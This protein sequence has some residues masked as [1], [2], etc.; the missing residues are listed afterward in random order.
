MQKLNYGYDNINVVDGEFKKATLY[1][2]TLVNLLMYFMS[3]VDYL[4]AQYRIVFRN[5]DSFDKITIVNKNSKTIKFSYYITNWV[6]YEIPAFNNVL[7]ELPKEVN[8]YN[9]YASD[10]YGWNSTNYREALDNL[11]LLHGDYVNQDIPYFEGMQSVKNSQTLVNLQQKGTWN[12]NGS[13]SSQNASYSSPL[14]T[15]L[16]KPSTK[17]YVKFNKDITTICKQF[18]FV[19]STDI[20]IPLTSHSN[21]A[22]GI[23]TTPSTLD[24]KTTPIHIYPKDK[25]SLTTKQLTDLHVMIIEYVE[26]MENW[27]IP[28]FEGTLTVDLE[29]ED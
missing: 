4:D 29:T 23:I 27:N 8:E 6:E 14:P 21:G 13:D 11:V 19:Q 12:I 2:Q 1:G 17:Y 5:V 10:T 3:N 25:T 16:L 9:F 28:Y 26:G 22:Y 20:I 7:I 24:S 15:S 18:Y